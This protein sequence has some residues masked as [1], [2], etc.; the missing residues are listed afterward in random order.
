MSPSSPVSAGILPSN[1]T[2]FL[3]SQ[4]MEVVQ[5]SIAD[6]PLIVAISGSKYLYHRGL[7]ERR[8]RNIHVQN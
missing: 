8:N 2:L 6:D 4:N 7:T 1:R 3:G 5:F